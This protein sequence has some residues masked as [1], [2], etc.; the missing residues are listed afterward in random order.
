MKLT[1]SSAADGGV[2]GV[3]N[4]GLGSEGLFIQGT[5]SARGDG[6]PCRR[7]SVFPFLPVQASPSPRRLV[8][9][10]G[11]DYEGYLFV[12]SQKAVSLTVALRDFANGNVTLASATLKFA[13]GD[14]TR[15]DFQLNA[16][17]GEDGVAGGRQS[18]T[19]LHA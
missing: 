15:L 1:R 11:K 12:K 8:V 9:P 14:W 6:D 13:G 17:Q 4:R 18:G 2:F 10:A 7:A 3:A 5:A 19:P 16:T